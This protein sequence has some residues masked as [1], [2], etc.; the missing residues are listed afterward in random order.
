MTDFQALIEKIRERNHIHT[1]QWIAERCDVGISTIAAIKDNP[2]RQPRH[3]LGEKLI[4]LERQT[5]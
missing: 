4:E 5:R 1:L 2:G 3:D